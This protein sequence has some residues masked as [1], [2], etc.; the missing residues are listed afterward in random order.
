MI[1]QYEYVVRQL[2][3]TKNKKHEQYVVTGIVHK[4]NRDDIK[5]V[6]QQYVKSESGRALTDLYF[7]AINLHIEIDE[8]FHLKQAEHDNLREADII[9]A[10]GHEVI[11]ISVDGSLRQMNKRIDDCVAAIKSKISALGDYFEPWDMDKELSIEPHIR[12]GYIDVKDNV[13]FR[14]ITDACNCFGHNYKFLQKAGAKHPYHDDILIWL[15]KL[16][17]NEHWSNQISNDENV[18]TE[19]PKSEDA[20][21]THFDK[22]MAETRNKRLVFAKA[23]DNLGMTL[24]RFKGL[25]ELNPKKSNRTIGLY[26]QRISTRVKTY[27]SPARNP[28]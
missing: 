16:F 26:W 22:W 7:P 6:T 21:A 9:D 14:R 18:I 1:S 2:A 25:Y 20:Q 24:Y 5:F 8:P 15:P 13:A 11:R 12:R 17:D 28:D 19:I 3:R 27:P 10:T 23:K 4:L